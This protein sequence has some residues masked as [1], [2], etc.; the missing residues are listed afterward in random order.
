MH[1]TGL[2]RLLWAL[3]LLGHCALLGV[4]LLRRRAP[5]FPAFTTLITV[6]ILRS[7][8]LYLILR[9]GRPDTYFYTYWTLAIVDV[10][11]QLAVAYELATHVFQPLGDWA[12]DVKRSLGA[13]A[14]IGRAHV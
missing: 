4:L 3:S 8:V 2:D 11:L 12:P 14:E 9:F 1:L 10:A 6:N 7:I 13:L 5:S